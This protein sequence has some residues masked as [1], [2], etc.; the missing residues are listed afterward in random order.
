MTTTPAAV[1]RE[2]DEVLSVLAGAGG[3]RNELSITNS[4]YTNKEKMWYPWE[5]EIFHQGRNDNVSQ[6]APYDYNVSLATLNL[7]GG[8]KYSQ[9]QNNKRRYLSSNIDGYQYPN[10]EGNRNLPGH[11]GALGVSTHQEDG[12]NHSTGGKHVIFAGAPGTAQGNPNYGKKDG[13]TMKDQDYQYPGYLLVHG[14]GYKSGNPGSNAWS[15][16][17]LNYGFPLPVAGITFDVTPCRAA[18]TLNGDGNN[19]NV[20]AHANSCSDWQINFVHGLWYPLAGNGDYVA[21]PLLPNGDNWEGQSDPKNGKY[22]FRNAR[23]M[24]GGSGYEKFGQWNSGVIDQGGNGG[25]KTFTIKAM[26]ERGT[27]PPANS[28]FMGFHFNMCFGTAADAKKEKMYFIS[29][30]DVIPMAAAEIMYDKPK[31]H[32]VNPSVEGLPRMVC[33]RLI[34]RYSFSPGQIPMYG[35]PEYW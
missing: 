7:L 23:S 30:V 14:K 24:S 21:R 4:R 11:I 32:G 5:P 10:S 16:Y 22:V 15:C 27:S 29:S 8:V 35:S 28:L 26:L 19:Y 17:S 18:R 12:H 31:Y 25:D 1:Y 33:P 3:V 20:T 9:N 34:S 6:G 2:E 13:L